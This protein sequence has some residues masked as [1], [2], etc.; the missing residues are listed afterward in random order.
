[1]SV[2]FLALSEEMIE[3]ARKAA[4]RSCGECSLCCYLLDVPEAGKP[5]GPHWCPHCRPGAGGCSIYDKRPDICRRYACMWLVN[6]GL[7]NHWR[8]LDAK[9]II[10]FDA[11]DPSEK[12]VRV[13]VD[14]SCPDRWREPPYF[15]DL[16]E[17]SRHFPVVIKCAKTP[18]P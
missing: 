6:P 13:T 5:D 8:P 7:G 3:Q 2:K 9:M 16:V 18:I 12:K 4:G 15:N 14:P 1:M 11:R 17:I 10:D